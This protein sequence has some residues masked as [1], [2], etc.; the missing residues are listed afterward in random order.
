ML[1]TLRG[2]P[3][4]YAGDEI[5]MA[6]VAVPRERLRDPVGVRN[7]P[8]DSGRDR[9][10]TP[11]QWTGEE[12]V[13]SR[14]PASSRGCRWGMRHAATS[15]ISARSLVRSVHLC[16]DLIALRRARDDLRRG[17]YRALE[18]PAGVWAWGRGE[19]TVVAVNL[20]DEHA[21][22]EL[23][24]GTVLV[25]TRRQRDGEPVRG[26][27][28]LEPW[29]GLVVSSE[30]PVGDGE[31]GVSIPDQGVRA[32]VEDA[33]RA[34]PNVRSVELVGS[35][36]T[37]TPDALSDWDFVVVGDDT[38]AVV[39]DLPSIV[40]P[41][42][43]LSQQ[44]DRLGPDEYSCYML[45]LAGPRKIDLI[46]PGMP[47]R[48]A[49][50]WVPGPDTLE[51]IDRHF[52]DWILWL[53]AKQRGGKDELVREQLAAMSVHLLQPMGVDDVPGSIREAVRRYLDVRGRLEVRF[54]RP[55]PT[56][57]QDAVLPVL[58]AARTAL[59]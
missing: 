32:A 12:Q 28:R 48:P 1:L 40:A 10:R 35:R 2:T 49:P 47:H 24:D 21:A 50:P 18:A 8:D 17:T 6:E 46:F 16:R 58:P 23:R 30:V 43:P 33:L 9:G 11:M 45:L 56:V 29:E 20:S 41:L 52:W 13:G 59:S 54:G 25:G 7:W 42:Q 4:L 19:G 26:T 5:G 34:D 39:R 31:R 14:S 15:P 51:A 55:V 37:G 38:D 57:L 53:A 22:L 44:W 36:A 3:I 27:V